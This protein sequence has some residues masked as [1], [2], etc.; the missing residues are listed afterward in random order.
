MSL[1]SHKSN[2]T[3]IPAK[4]IKKDYND[5]IDDNEDAHIIKIKNIFNKDIIIKKQEKNKSYVN[6]IRI[7]KKREKNNINENNNPIN[8]V[9]MNNN[10]SKKDLKEIK[11]KKPKVY[12]N[13]I[14]ITKELAAIRRINM[15]IEE[16]KNN[17]PQIKM[18]SE[19]RKNRFQEEK[20]IEDNPDNNNSK[21]DK[22]NNSINKDNKKDN[23][24]SK[25]YRF[26]SDRRLSEIQK[27]TNNSFSKN[28]N[29]NNN[30]I[31][32]RTR[33]KSNKSMMSKLCNN[34]IRCVKP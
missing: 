12:N 23:N 24:K 9:K 30:V 17:K 13:E 6:S 28:K 1:F 14:T 8:C 31:N 19:R 5:D 2:K 32:K 29:N 4:V 7:I 11:E 21:N 33:N 26:Q 20:K 22:N 34:N 3:N 18:I 16:F 15:K 25:D 10:Q 27:R